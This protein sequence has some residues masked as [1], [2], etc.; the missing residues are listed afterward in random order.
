MTFVNKDVKSYIP[1]FD[2]REKADNGWIETKKMRK[3]PQDREYD[4]KPHREQ[5]WPTP[6]T[7]WA[8]FVPD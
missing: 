3:K 8:I 7:G 6:N 5:R 1:R 2:F 4:D